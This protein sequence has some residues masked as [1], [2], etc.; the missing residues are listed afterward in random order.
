M[1][2]VNTVQSGHTVH[3]VH[4]VHAVHTVHSEHI[5][6]TVHTAQYIL[7]I[8]Y[9]GSLHM[10]YILYYTHRTV[11]HQ[12]YTECLG[13]L[14]EETLARFKGSWMTSSDLIN[15]SIPTMSQVGSASDDEDEHTEQPQMLHPENASEVPKHNDGP[16][17]MCV[18]RTF[19]C[20][21]PRRAT[22]H[23]HET[24]STTDAHCTG[25][26][27]SSRLGSQQESLWLWNLHNLL[28]ILFY[29]CLIHLTFDT[30]GVF[31][32]KTVKEV[33]ACLRDG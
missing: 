5:V 20:L 19:V 7:Y 17:V 1:H 16:L 22:H 31:P 10:M 2:I 21:A 24:A 27:D 13:Y 3:I 25:F 18:Q 11:P 23:M 29:F 6:N 33:L 12:T 28:V 32:N 9:V 30:N 8:L 4:T 15:E 14:V 26:V